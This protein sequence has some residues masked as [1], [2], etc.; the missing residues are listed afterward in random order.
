MKLSKNFLIAAALVL[1]TGVMTGLTACS[2][3]EKLPAYF[4]AD[5][6]E[7]T[8]EYDGLTDA[9]IE[10]SFTLNTNGDWRVSQKDEWIHMS[11]ESGTRGSHKI[12]VTAD[13]NT[14]GED[15]RGFVEIQ[16]SG[17]D[18][19]ELL[20]VT[21]NRKVGTL[22]IT[23]A[24][25]NVTT[26]GDAA[27]DESLS[28]TIDTNYDW[29]IAL[30]EDCDWIT[31]GK[32]AG[33]A[34]KE[35]VSFSVALNATGAEREAKITVT[36]GGLSRY[37]TVRQDGEAFTVKADGQPVGKLSFAAADDLVANLTVGCIESWSVTSKPEWITV[38][39]D[40]GGVG[41][42][43]V[44]VTAEANA[45][46]PREGYITITTAHGLVL[47]A[48][49]AQLSSKAQPDSKEIGYV[50]FSDDFSWVEGGSDQVANING[51]APNDAR[52]IYTWDFAGNGFNNVLS[53][54]N[55]KYTDYNAGA[56][57]VY[58][59]DGYLKFNKGGAQTA[60]AIKD[61]LP[62]E[63]GKYAD[64][65]VTFL[66]AKN[67]T[68]P[69]TV[70]VVIEGAGEIEGGASAT[71]SKE[72]EPYNNSDKTIPW[73]WT[74]MTVTVRGAT[75]ATK[76]IIGATP[77]I[78]NGF[79]AVETYPDNGKTSYYRWFMDDLKVTRIETK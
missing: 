70:S 9:G 2:D 67:G 20:A 53:V 33:N 3:D 16:L 48:P 39:P 79:K 58:A 45:G 17:S 19:K 46:E 57:V 74:P 56:K 78:N 41:E 47:T 63:N 38:A 1:S 49:V 68:D 34:G 22:S 61:E 72:L 52:N 4:K 8:L 14:T 40:N 29:T 15:R 18:K 75:A 30:P 50:Y 37:T 60:I 51:G 26:L 31:L 11:R 77:F 44:V 69:M 10:P 35:M 59:M 65:E 13:E 5:N 71:Q 12:F 7:F 27:A 54:F 21:Q 42:T 73:T 66:A 36:A 64:V 76:I 32:Q 43:E 55:Q 23:P 24:L 62:I 28:F 25:V 6:R